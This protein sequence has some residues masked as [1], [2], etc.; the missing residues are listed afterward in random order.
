MDVRDV[1]IREP[2]VED[3]PKMIAFLQHVSSEPGLGVVWEPGEFNP[4]L[5]QEERFIIGHAEAD[6]S[7]V[8]VADAGGEIV[9]VA[10]CT[11]GQRRANRHSCVLGISIAE[12]WRDRGLGTAIMQRLL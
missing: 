8:L 9:A 3:A 10:D 7:I 6:N 4:T 11:G 5:E 2:R 12:E 1:V